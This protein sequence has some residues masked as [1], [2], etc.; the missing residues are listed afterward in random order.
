MKVGGADSM[1][2]YSYLRNVTDLLSD[3]KTP[4]GKTFW[5]AI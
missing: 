1:E 5:E 4:Y 2:V 3:G